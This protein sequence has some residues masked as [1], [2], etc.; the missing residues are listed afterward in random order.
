METFP[1]GNEYT[2]EYKQGKMNGHG[3]FKWKDGDEYN[4]NWVDG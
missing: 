1:D 3:V 2:G 4:G